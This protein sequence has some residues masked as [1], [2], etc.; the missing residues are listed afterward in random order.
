[1]K[2]ETGPRPQK[3]AADLATQKKGGIRDEL[4]TELRGIFAEGGRGFSGGV[5]NFIHAEIGKQYVEG[6]GYQPSDMP[7]REKA[8]LAAALLQ[9]MKGEFPD[10]FRT[11]LPSGDPKQVGHEGERFYLQSM[12]EQ[13]TSLATT[14]ELFSTIGEPQQAKRARS[15]LPQLLEHDVELP[16]RTAAL[17][18]RV[19][20][21]AGDRS[22]ALRENNKGGM[23]AGQQ[24][25]SKTSPALMGANLKVPTDVANEWKGM[26]DGIQY[27]VDRV[28]QGRLGSPAADV[29]LQALATKAPA[30]VTGLWSAAGTQ[31]RAKLNGA[32]DELARVLPHAVVA[33]TPGAEPGSII[34]R[35]ADESAL[36]NHINEAIFVGD[37]AKAKERAGE[38][39]A[40]FP[41]APMAP[42]AKNI[43]AE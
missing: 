15:V 10:A 9:D 8:A 7:L 28:K 33:T 27:V 37:H 35:R 16:V 4:R 22:K 21:D 26:L 18:V 14:G 11:A 36:S 39:L 38:Y 20:E 42:W 41:N 32:L 31:M 23:F 34:E 25:A 12:L 19:L 1:M 40:K 29:E 2:V 24:T 30:D 3:V 5:D 6:K 13:M 17:E 43:L